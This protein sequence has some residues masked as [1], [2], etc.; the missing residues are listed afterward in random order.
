MQILENDMNKLSMQDAMHRGGV[1]HASQRQGSV[2]PR[3][4]AEQKGSKRYS[5]LRQRSL[6]E[7]T[8]PPF[9]QHAPG[10][11]AAGKL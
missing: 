5:S 9:N 7:T 6:P 11:Y 10:Y 2:P 3:L 8:A 1:K 4:Q